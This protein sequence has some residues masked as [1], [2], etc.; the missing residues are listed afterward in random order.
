MSEG[1]I[2]TYETLF[3]ILRREKSRD[4]LQELDQDFYHNVADYLKEKISLLSTG[5]ENGFLDEEEKT[6]IQ[7]SN[8]KKII[9]ELYERRERKIV[10][11][12]MFKARL[13]NKIV[14][15]RALL[16]EEQTLF[17]EISEKLETKRI[18]F[19]DSIIQNG[20]GSSATIP[21]PQQK[22]SH[23]EHKPVPQQDSEPQPQP[24]EKEQSFEKKPS[25][26][27]ETLMRTDQGE[28]K[29][30]KEISDEENKL[31]RFLNPVPKFLGTE[32][33]IYGPYE[34]ED[35]ANLPSRIAQILIQ[36]G[37]AEEIAK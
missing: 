36:K 18:L 19:L 17:N 25:A 1:V 9:K 11:L 10:N 15:T 22:T 5:S 26:E 12:A 16:P 20:N 4:E 37:R 28:K 21:N 2:I 6:K 24:N 29:S 23:Q 34:E 14:D 35:V 13:K 3:D 7:I 33:E 31:V 32:L 30:D 8:I 27:T